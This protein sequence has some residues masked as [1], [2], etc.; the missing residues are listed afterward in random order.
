MES[1]PTPLVMPSPPITFIFFNFLLYLVMPPPLTFRQKWKLRGHDSVF[2]GNLNL[3]LK[4]F[5]IFF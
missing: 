4:R 1:C 3:K 5:I 2:Y